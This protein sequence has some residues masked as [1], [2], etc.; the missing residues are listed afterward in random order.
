MIA[1]VLGE[2]IRQFRLAHNWTQEKLSSVLCISHQVVSKWENGLTTP[3]AETLCSLAQI[4]GVSLDELCGISPQKVNIIIEEIEQKTNETNSTYHSLYS[5]WS[6]IEKHLSV[7]PTNEALLFSALQFLRTMYNKVETEEQ[8][9][10]TNALILKIAERILDFSKNDS[11][12]SFAHYNLAL[13]YSAQ[14]SLKNSDEQN[15]SYAEKAK[16]HADLVL[17]KDMHKTFYHSFGTISAEEERTA[18]EKTLVEL[19]DATK[20]A[21]EN[22]LRHYAHHSLEND[23]TAKNTCFALSEFV[24]QLVS[25][26]NTLPFSHTAIPE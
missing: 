22:L 1:N 17:Y 19:L 14:V 7:Y 11:H 25:F 23:H 5:E 24:N 3:D 26:S 15:K 21:C 20:R 9:D 2:N 16:N 12:R 13:Y 18:R 10:T 4:F 8:K 6:I